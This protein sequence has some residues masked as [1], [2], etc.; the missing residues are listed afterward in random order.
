M[1]VWI[2]SL[3]EPTVVDNTRPMRYMSIQNALINAGHDVT[4]FSCTFRHAN[5]Q[6]RFK[7]QHLHT[8]NQHKTVF[9]EAPSY[10]KNFSYSRVKSHDIYTQNLLGYLKKISLKPDII[11]CAFPPIETAYRLS[12][13][14]KDEGIKFV[15]DII[16][17][18]P[19]VI[20]QALPKI[21]FPVTKCMIW[22]YRKK[23]RQILM[24][25]D[26]VVAISSQ[27]TEWAKSVAPGAS[28]KTAVFY[29]SVPLREVRSKLEKYFP[30]KGD[31]SMLKLIYAG[32]LG[33]AYDIPCIIKAFTEIESTHPS[34]VSVTIAGVGHYQSIV[35]EASKK[36]PNFKYIGRIGYDELL[37]QYAFS[38]LGLAQYSVGATQSVT[39]K[40]FDYLGAGLP[41]L[42]SLDSEMAV[43]IDRF[44]VGYNNKPADYMQ[45]ADN[46]RIYLTD[47]QRLL[48][49]KSKAISTTKDIG[50][51]EVVYN[52]L[53]DF[54]S[55]QVKS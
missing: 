6:F 9:I 27:Y 16:D 37:E 20:Q 5:K 4:F 40:L 43:L 41:V 35:E 25:S 1:R 17:P 11:I 33:V 52:R 2:V 15:L 23:V 55:E 22:Y 49:Q 13:W 45:L 42:N 31:V 39:Y 50:D 34:K 51:N 46:I 36:Y 30:N 48:I 53:V 38:D 47:S 28:F 29:P 26:A 12:K 7:Q 21:T 8:D 3:F 10:E 32:N 44:D 54:L 19:D 14:A 18:W 24:Q